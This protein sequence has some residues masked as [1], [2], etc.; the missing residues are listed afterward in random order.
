MTIYVIL[1]N[2]TQKRI[3]T[4][5]N[6]PKDLEEA[7]KIFK[8][9]GVKIKEL[10]FTMGRY[11]VVAIG[12]APNEETITKALLHWGSQGLLRTETLTGFAPEKMAELLKEI[13]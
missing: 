9:Y 1:G 10:V 6:L 7:K 3:D 4:I 13:K 12:E 5:K 11:D 8:S 2:F